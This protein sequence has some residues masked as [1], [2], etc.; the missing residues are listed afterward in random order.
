MITMHQCPEQIEMEEEE[1]MGGPCN[2][3]DCVKPILPFI[4]A[5]HDETSCG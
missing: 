2:W 5:V 3:K 1:N 4:K